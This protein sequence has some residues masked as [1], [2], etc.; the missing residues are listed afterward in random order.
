MNKKDILGFVYINAKNFGF[1]LIKFFIK[2]FLN[3]HYFLIT[4]LIILITVTIIII[5]VIITIITIIMFIIIMV[6]VI[7]II[8]I[9]IIIMTIINIIMTITNI[10]IYSLINNIV[11]R[12]KLFLSIPSETYLPI[13][14]RKLWQP[15][16]L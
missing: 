14:P 1:S 6:I 9:A 12:I 4:I 16:K 8:I 13:T 15:Q 7:I 11:L 5:N 3:Y 2:R 10:I